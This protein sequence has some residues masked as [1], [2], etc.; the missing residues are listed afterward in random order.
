MDFGTF[1]I[2]LMSVGLASYQLRTEFQNEMEQRQ[3]RDEL[4][5][6]K[7]KFELKTLNLTLE[8]MRREAENQNLR[9]TYLGMNME[10]C[11]KEK[12]KEFDLGLGDTFWTVTESI[13]KQYI[14]WISYI[15]KKIK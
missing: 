11:K 7:I 4:E 2:V 14:A 5:F 12:N 13:K 6:E 9:I 8:L 3:L 15:T 1:L 10:L